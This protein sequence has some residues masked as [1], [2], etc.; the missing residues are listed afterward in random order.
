MW[1]SIHCRYGDVTSDIANSVAL[2][3]GKAVYLVDSGIDGGKIDIGVYHQ[4]TIQ[5]EDVRKEHIRRQ[6]DD[7]REKGHCSYG[8]LRN[9]GH[10]LRDDRGRDLRRE[11]GGEL[12]SDQ[13]ESEH[14]ERGIFKE[15]EHRGVGRLLTSEKNTKKK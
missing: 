3:V 13:R 14:I 6:N 4:K 9:I 2:G 15:N 10:E 5:D 12:P 7:A 11:R 1:T 8:L